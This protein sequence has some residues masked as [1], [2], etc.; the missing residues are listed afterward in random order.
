[1]AIT[2]TPKRLLILQAMSDML[3]QISVANGYRTDVA[4]VV[5]GRAVISDNE[6]TPMVS[7]IEAPVT[8]EQME[9]AG[10]GYAIHA[11]WQLLVQGWAKDDPAHPTDPVYPLLYDVRRCLAQMVDR[12]NKDR[13]LLKQPDGSFL[14]HKASIGFGM[15]R[16]PTPNISSRAFFYLPVE[17]DLAESADD[18]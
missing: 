11:G 7:I 13:Y 9:F 17:V 6:P 15:V 4:Q 16:P 5:R 14:I 18:V 3:S 2:T 12:D 8:H 10:N 1:M